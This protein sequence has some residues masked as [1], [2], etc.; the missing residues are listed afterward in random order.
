ML[1]NLANLS[2]RRKC[3]SVGAPLSDE[4]KKAMLEI[5]C[6]I[7]SEMLKVPSPYW[8]GRSDDPGAKEWTIACFNQHVFHKACLKGAWNGAGR[9]NERCPDCRESPAQGLLAKSTDWMGTPPPPPS[10]M[11]RRPSEDDGQR[12]LG[13][14]MRVNPTLQGLSANRPALWRV[15]RSDNLGEQDLRPPLPIDT[16]RVHDSVET[17]LIAVRALTAEGD[18]RVNLRVL[19]ARLTEV[20]YMQQAV[21]ENRINYIIFG[22][23]LIILNQYVW[24]IRLPVGRMQQD[25]IVKLVQEIIDAYTNMARQAGLTWDVPAE[26][27][28][29]NDMARLPDGSL[30]QTPAPA[31]APAPAVVPRRVDYGPARVISAWGFF[32]E[33]QRAVTDDTKQRL[34]R[35]TAGGSQPF[36]AFVEAL[37]AVNQLWEQ[38]E[39]AVQGGPMTTPDIEEIAGA[40][41]TFYDREAALERVARSASTVFD[42]SGALS[43]ST[44]FAGSYLRA[45]NEVWPR[46]GEVYRTVNEERRPANNARSRVRL[47]GR[48]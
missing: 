39:S 2:L 32:Q 18:S 17:T 26:R 7:C 46:F 13:M 41:N 9:G 8:R 20:G 37:T 1:P 3:L 47:F 6:N 31:P 14:R 34:S 21:L 22:L 38:R 10:R 12:P 4:V 16:A 44:V 33:K 42:V 28:R 5:E 24:G 30:A 48:R 27:F 35:V 23:L 45:L 11:V 29:V 19:E 40:L 25:A 36:E 43:D 15:P